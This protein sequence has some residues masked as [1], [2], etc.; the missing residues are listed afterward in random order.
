[1]IQ[2]EGGAHSFDGNHFRDD[3]LLVC[4]SSLDETVDSIA[5]ELEFVVGKAALDCLMPTRIEIP[6]WLSS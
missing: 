4:S 5:W 2:G 1:M 3:V 6:T